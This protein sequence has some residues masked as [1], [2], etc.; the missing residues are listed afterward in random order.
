MKR[1]IFCNLLGIVLLSSLN[2]YR[3]LNKLYCKAPVSSSTGKTEDI[4]LLNKR[5]DDLIECMILIFEQL[6]NSN[7]IF[8]WALLILINTNF[9]TTKFPTTKFL[10]TKR[11]F[12]FLKSKN[13]GHKFS[14]LTF[15][16]S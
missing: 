4:P 3:V 1:R 8:S 15:E 6:N 13:K 5:L 7:D 10:T 14:F 9:P 2:S 16:P 11:H 12:F